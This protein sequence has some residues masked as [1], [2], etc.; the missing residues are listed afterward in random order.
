M[1]SKG[2]QVS[3]CKTMTEGCTTLET[4]DCSNNEMFKKHAEKYPICR[5]CFHSTI[6]D[7]Y[8]LDIKLCTILK[9]LVLFVQSLRLE[10][11]QQQT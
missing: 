10:S 7:G 9:L 11:G 5:T 8:Y 2:A 4:M 1:H 6:K 3:S